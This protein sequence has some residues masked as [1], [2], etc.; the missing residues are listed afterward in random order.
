MLRTIGG[1]I[2]CAAMTVALSAQ[3]T[4][5]IVTFNETNGDDMFSAMIQGADGNLYGTTTYGGASD[6][7]TFFRI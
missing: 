5:T 2:V 4:K 7:G 3:V 1:A 6:K